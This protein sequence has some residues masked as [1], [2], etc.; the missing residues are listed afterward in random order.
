[1]ILNEKI[2]IF[3]FASLLIFT[4]C[5]ESKKDLSSYEGVWKSN[6]SSIPDEELIINS[7]KDDKIKFDYVLYRLGEFTDVEG[8]IDGE[9]ASFTA[10]NENEWTI[11]GTL[12]LKDDKVVLNITDSSIDLIVK[13]KKT[14]S[15]KS[16]KS[17]IRG[18]SNV[19]PDL[20]VISYK[21]VWRN[22]DSSNPVDEFIIIEIN[23][24][25]ITFEYL[26][27]GITTFENGNAT[28]DGNKANFDI[29]NELGWTLKGYFVMENDEVALTITES[30]SDNIEKTTIVYKL[31]REESKLK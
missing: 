22:D 5:G 14:F 19:E 30:S 18:N 8:T 12:T 28:L 25:T 29:T 16:D 3:V 6:D 20:D 21:G 13:D 27:D 10:K 1:M 2:L 17:S 26:I 9:E 31:H 23:G 15:V 7:I 24:N 11:K 4:G